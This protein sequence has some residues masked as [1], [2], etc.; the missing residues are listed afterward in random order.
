MSAARSYVCA[1]AWL[2]SLVCIAAQRSG[3]IRFPAPKP[4]VS[5]SS[6]LLDR[7]EHRASL[8]LLLLLILGAAGLTIG[9]PTELLLGVRNDGRQEIL[10]SSILASFHNLQHFDTLVTNVRPTLCG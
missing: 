3:A 7:P 5:T 4:S 9:E 1:V 8:V 10:L 2:L 6:V